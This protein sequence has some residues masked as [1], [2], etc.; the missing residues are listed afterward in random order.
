MS[1]SIVSHGIFLISLTVHYPITRNR[2]PRD[3]H[4]SDRALHIIVRFPKAIRRIHNDLNSYDLDPQDH[5]AFFS[6][7]TNQTRLM[8][9][10]PLRIT[11]MYR[12]CHLTER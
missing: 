4:Y 7:K 1:V 9:F 3:R 10:S 12:N 5:V 2:F 11:I 6:C 8:V